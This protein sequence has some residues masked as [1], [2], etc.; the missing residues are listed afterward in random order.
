M[1]SAC[2]VLHLACLAVPHNATLSHKVHH[3]RK[4]VIKHENVFLCFLQILSQI[5]LILKIIQLDI[6]TNVHTFSCKIPVVIV[7]F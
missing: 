6:V 4:E 2:F 1:Q 7:R 5:F 3:I